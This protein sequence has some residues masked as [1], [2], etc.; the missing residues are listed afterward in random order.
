MVTGKHHWTDLAILCMRHLLCSLRGKPIAT[1][2]Q[3]S[4][5]RSPL[6]KPRKARNNSPP[7][8]P[9]RPFLINISANSGASGAPPFGDRQPVSHPIAARV[10]RPSIGVADVGAFRRLQSLAPQRAT[11]LRSTL[12]EMIH[13]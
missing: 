11:S 13:S 6:K 12:F 5:P 2:D 3:Y 10:V 8:S 9:R 4:E 1:A 7:S